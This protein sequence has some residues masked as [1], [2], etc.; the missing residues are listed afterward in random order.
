MHFAKLN[1]P[2]H[3]LSKV[4]EKICSPGGLN[5]GFTVIKLLWLRSRPSSLTCDDAF[6]YVFL[7]AL[8]N[9]STTF[10]DYGTFHFYSVPIH[11]LPKK[12][13][14]LRR[15][16]EEGFREKN[17]MSPTG[18]CLKFFWKQPREPGNEVVF[19]AAFVATVCRGKTNCFSP[20]RGPVFPPFCL[21]SVVASSFR[22]LKWNDRLAGTKL[23]SSE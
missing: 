15:L 11:P 6:K 9:Y 5:R 21:Y 10:H 12:S 1:K 2:P 14:V 3:L 4:L 7:F 16:C 22:S 19:E 8:T 17:K 23:S 13:D 18:W 20:I